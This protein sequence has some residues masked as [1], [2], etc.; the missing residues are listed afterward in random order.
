MLQEPFAPG[1]PFIHRLDPRIRLMAAG[2]L[3]FV[4]ALS[5]DVQVMTTALLLSPVLVMLAHL[6]HRELIRRILVVNCFNLR[7]WLILPFTFQGLYSW[8]VGPFICYCAGI[9]MAAGVTLKSNAI[10]LIL[11]TLE[12]IMNFSLIGYALNW[13]RVPG[14]LVHLL[15]MTYRHV[16]M[17]DQEYRRLIRAAQIR[18]FQPRNNLHTYQ[19]YV[20]IVG[21]LLVHSYRRAD[22]VYKAMPCRGFK[23]RFYCLRA[24]KIG[25]NDWLFGAVTGGAILILIYLEIR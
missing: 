23:H 13:L 14:Q 6:P 15:L 11:S 24:F 12:T 3:S 7:L 9:I 1:E 16:F 20:Y 4:V 17:I 19:T 18:G 25:Q 21:M 22:R 5:R 8:A 2:I 10:L